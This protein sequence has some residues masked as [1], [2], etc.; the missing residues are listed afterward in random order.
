[1]MSLEKTAGVILAGG[2]GRRMFASQPA[3]GDKSLTSL[4]GQP[5]IAHVIARLAPQVPRIIIN[6]N[7]DPSR[8]KRFGLDV[9]KDIGDAGEGPLA[10]LF[11]AMDWVQRTDSSITALLTVSTDTPFLPTDLAH[12]LLAECQGRPA[13]AA[14]FGQ[15]H[16]VIGLW[17]LTLRESLTQA[18]SE[19][20]RSVEK[21]ARQHDA[22]A[23]TFGP[24]TIAGHMIDPFFNANTPDDLARAQAILAP[25]HSNEDHPNG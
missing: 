22:V 10:G 21:F 17:P 19:K 8:F 4:A 2:T 11:A 9:V 1:M 24:V 20:R 23:V 12:R 13:I 6:A 3:G 14:S 18:L 15:V 16:P 25:E 7:G 5:M